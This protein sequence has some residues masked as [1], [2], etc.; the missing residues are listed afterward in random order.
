M[1]IQAHV[2]AAMIGDDQI[3]KPRSRSANTTCPE[4]TLRI[5]APDAGADEDALQVPAPSARLL[6][7]TVADVAL[8]RLAQLA[9]QRLQNRCRQSRQVAGGGFLPACD[10]LPVA[11][12]LSL[13]LC[14]LLLARLRLFLQ[15]VWRRAGA[16]Q[17][18]G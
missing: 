1:A 2:T 3:A 12:R 16:V 9:T 15:P 11:A 18:D 14:P 8:Y 13:L 4:A 17:S 6:P 5:S 7:K 10:Y